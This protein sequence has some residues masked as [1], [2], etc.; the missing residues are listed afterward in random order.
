MTA[1][2]VA[3]G[4]TLSACG[5]SASKPAAPAG[6]KDPAAARAAQAYVDAYTHHQAKRICALLADTVRAQLT[7]KGSCAATIRASFQGAD[8]RLAVAGATRQGATA[9]ATFK[10]SSR[11]VTLRR[12]GAAWKVVDGG[13]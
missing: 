6:T 7:Q 9:V 11:Q 12:Q 8:P 2:L 13:T 3:S 5:G 10:G 4:L 1:V